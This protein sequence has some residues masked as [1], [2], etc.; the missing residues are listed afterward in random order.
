M[1]VAES[2]EV[3]LVSCT[4]SAVPPSAD[5]NSAKDK[6][7]SVGLSTTDVES[8]DVSKDCKRR[9][10]E[11]VLQYED[12]FSRHHLDCGE[13]NGFVHHI[14]QK[15]RQVLRKMEKKETIL[16]LTSEYASQLVLVWKKMELC[17]SVQTF[18]G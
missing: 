5:A 15:L 13:A 8:C 10:A 7:R 2:S 6:L 11:L 12:V 16:K 9:M 18:A 1:D 17:A 3:P 14:H 4:Q